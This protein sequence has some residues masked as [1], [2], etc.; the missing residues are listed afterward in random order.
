MSKRHASRI[1]CSVESREQVKGQKRGGESYDE[2]LRKMVEQY[3]PK[4]G[5]N[6]DVEPAGGRGTKIPC[7]HKTR[8]LVK[9]QKRGGETYDELLPKM[10][11]Q[12]HPAQGH[13][14][15][16]TRLRKRGNA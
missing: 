9:G 7:S 2:V 6:S 13:Q 1:D 5:E 4:A 12:Y 15:P 14:N 11:E 16:D 3:D 10:V 8:A